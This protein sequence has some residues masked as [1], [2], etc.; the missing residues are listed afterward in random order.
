MLASMPAAPDAVFQFVP[1]NFDRADPAVVGRQAASHGFLSAFIRHGGTA[2]LTALVSGPADGE[3][4]RAFAA[5]AGAG[6]RPVE[7]LL[8]G[9]LA[10]AARLGTVWRPGPDIGHL[11]WLRRAVGSRAFSVCGINHTLSD[12]PA[13]DAIGALL[14]APLEGWDALVCTS[15]SSRAVITTLLEGWGEFLA[16][17]FGGA[18]P[19]LPRL[20]VIP[21]GIDTEAFMASPGEREALRGQW[22]VPADAVVALYVGRLNHVEKAN[23]A[24]MYLA[25]ER[26][27]AQTRRPLVL[28]EAG[29]F[30]SAAFEQAFRAAAATLM[31]SVRHVL[32]DG[33]TAAGRRIW[34]AGDLFLSLTDNI[35]ETF[36]LTPIEAMAAGLP[37][38]A[39]DWDGYRETVR[40]GIDGVLVPTLL[41]PAGAGAN[42]AFYYAAG[43]AN[44]GSFAGAAAQSTAVDIQ[45][46]GDAVARLANDPE[47]RRRLGQAGRRR[48]RERY[49][50]RVIVAA[51]QALWEE[52]AALR[53]SLPETAPDLTGH[54]L[55]PDPFALFAGFP[56]TRMAADTVLR[57]AEGADA[58]ALRA[59][60]H[61]AVL[62]PL[63][64]L[65]PDE[66]AL[67]AVLERLRAGPLRAADVLGDPTEA[68]WLGLGWLAKAGLIRWT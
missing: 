29:W 1:T 60:R 31:P 65:L 63:P 4:F 5:T 14:T 15:E 57:L 11:A 30:P 43:F 47:L 18:P 8:P 58:T 59:L 49:D 52:L 27:A 61:I 40:H 34:Q 24:P 42:L 32:V 45:A 33:R 66:E 2:S 56:T 7:V 22:G 25:L 21:L 16:G 13:M 9:D 53:Q 51:H 12:H 44:H 26:A 28:I 54:P 50:G 10:R 23:P 35:Q 41:P 17:R 46:A 64:T 20:P 62:N 38:V 6:T 37:V 3:A 39:G 55:R 67:A 19:P 48:A 68:G 36:G